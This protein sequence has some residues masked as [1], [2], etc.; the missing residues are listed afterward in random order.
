MTDFD[1]DNFVR[2]GHRIS[3]PI[4]LAWTKGIL[5]GLL[6][7]LILSTVVYYDTTPPSPLAPVVYQT[8]PLLPVM[9]TPPEK[10]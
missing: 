5:G 8:Q 7:A 10:Q 4:A 6:V 1:A 2:P 9:P 3:D